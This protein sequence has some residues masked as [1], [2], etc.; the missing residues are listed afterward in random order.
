MLAASRIEIQKYSATFAQFAAAAVFMCGFA[1]LMGWAFDVA[2]LTTM[3]LGTATMKPNTAIGFMLC[4]LSLWCLSGASLL[5]AQRRRVGQ[6]SAAVALILALLTMT[7]YATGASFG[8]DTLIFHDRLIA[9]GAAHPGR[10]AFNTALCLLF[11]SSSLLMVDIETRRGRPAEWLLL[12]ALSICYV[13]LLGYLYG[14]DALVHFGPYATMSLQTVLALLILCAGILFARTRSGLIGLLMSNSAGGVMGRRLLPA[15]ILIPVFLGWVSTLGGRMGWYQDEFG[16]ALLVASVVFIFVALI[17]KNIARLNSVDG[18]RMRAAHEVRRGAEMLT[19]IVENSHAVI[20]LKDLSGRFLTVNRRFADILGLSVD[21]VVGKTSHD[22]FPKHDA[23]N[24][25]ALDRRVAAARHTMVEEEEAVMLG[26]PHTFL[27]VKA[28]LLDADGE[29]YAI[30][31]ISTDITDRKQVEAERA[32]LLI[33]ES[34]AREDAE[35]LNSVARALA[36][37]LDLK[38]IVQV[39]TDSATKLTGAAFGAFFYNVLD[40]KGESFFLFTI[41]GAPREAF[42]HFGL[43]R[44]TAIFDPTFR[45][46]G[47][48]RLGDVRADPRYGKNA[49]HFGLPKGHLPVRSYLAVPVVARHGEVFGGLFFGH[50]EPNVFSERAERIALGIAAQAAVGIDNARLYQEATQ[51]QAKLETQLGR[52]R[53]L[54][55]ITRAIAERLDLPSILQVVLGSLEEHLPIDFACV[56]LYDAA[57]AVL[58]VTRV[59]ARSASLAKELE[60]IE[61]AQIRVDENGLA[62]CVGGQLVYEPDIADSAAQFPQRLA[63]CGLRSFVAAPLPV[64]SWVVGVLIVARREPSSFSSL[65]CEF[66]RQLAEHVALAANQAQ[67]N[68]SLQRAYDDLR[69]TQESVLQQERLRA[70]GTMASGVAHD[71]N[72]AISPVALYTEALLEYEAGLSDR[73]RSQLTIIKNS[74]DGV[75][76]TVARLREFYRPQETQAK[77]TPVNLNDVVQRV[78]ALTRARWSDIPQKNGRVISLETDLAADLPQIA[79]AENEIR[80]GLT[81]LIFNAADSMPEGGVLKVATW[82]A[83]GNVCIEVRDSGI[84][85]DEETRRRC[86][87][88]FFTTKGE[89]GTGLGLPMVYGMVKRHDGNLEI[90][91]ERGRG[92]T[93]RMLLPV[94]ATAVASGINDDIGQPPLPAASLRILIVD[95]DP[96]LLQSLKEVLEREGHHVTAADGGRAGIEAFERARANGDAFA[97]V[98]TDLGMPHVDGR[99][100]AAAVRKAVPD[101]PVIMLTGWGQRLLAENDIPPHVDRVLSKPPKLV[102]LRAALAGIAP[103]GNTH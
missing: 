70:L 30:I 26:E 34:A 93:V 96:M 23:D 84:G 51:K 101:V 66:L 28:P 49:P 57:S 16:R 77:L 65:D 64:E 90:D 3:A 10:M 4:A 42:E 59:G 69:Q 7:G 99:K 74:I 46:T 48:V 44:N 89:L 14:A 15:A 72:N 52:L 37:G 56:C 2:V 82:A 102:E 94:R 32:K 92:T 29:P 43:P 39:A 11:A 55:E 41:S 40:D 83:R 54:D 68:E 63:K 12:A 45:G 13:G 87:E 103:A 21:A 33:S 38:E 62:R 19:A 53:L 58:T 79:G 35:A 18:E 1:A 27:S 75:A 71:I 36:S 31:G 76:Q 81:N 80:N 22:L 24:Y 6:V 8:I 85:M 61:Q 5:S 97:A 9:T 17:W 67:L 60:L 47:P 78:L 50:P 86:L 25:A 95:D 98:I 73:A 88:P 91:S 20:Y 100:V